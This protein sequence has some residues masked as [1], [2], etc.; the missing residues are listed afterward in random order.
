MP[1]VTRL[2]PNGDLIISADRSVRV[3]R[4]NPMIEH[5][6][7]GIDFKPIHNV[8]EVRTQMVLPAEAGSGC[9]H[10]WNELVEPVGIEPTTSSLQS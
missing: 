3:H 5:R 8:K 4:A 7:Y 9:L 2:S 6:I 10:P 1:S